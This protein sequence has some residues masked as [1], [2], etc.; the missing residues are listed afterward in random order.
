MTPASGANT[1]RSAVR[2]RRSVRLH[3]AFEVAILIKG[4]DGMLQLIGGFVLLAVPLLTI[5]NLISQ[6]VAHELAGESDDLISRAIL[7]AVHELPAGTKTFAT[8]YLLAHGCVKLFMVYALWRE[9]L[10]AF[11]VALSI[12]GTFVVYQI[13][14]FAHTH[15][16][17]LLAFTV[18]D[19]AICWLIWREYGARRQSS[20]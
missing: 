9:K 10:W 5:N 3:E 18:I 11:P 7:H 12:I 19:I 8:V 2:A 20:P 16:L 15:S 17:A 14:R 13:Y 6:I 4:I 1:P